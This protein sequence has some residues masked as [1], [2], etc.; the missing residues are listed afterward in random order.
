MHIINSILKV[1]SVKN[2]WTSPKMTSNN[3]AGR[4]WYGFLLLL[5]V[6]VCLR[7]GGGGGGGYTRYD[8]F[9]SL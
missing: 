9:S 2:Q 5:L 1:A 3:S 4:F 8:D 6:C 7:G